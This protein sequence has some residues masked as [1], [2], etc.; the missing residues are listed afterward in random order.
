MRKRVL[1]G[2]VFTLAILFAG[3]VI[4]GSADYFDEINDAFNCLDSKVVSASLSFEEAVFAALAGTP[5]SRVSAMIVQQKSPSEYCWPKSGCTVK[6][7]AQAALAKMKMGEGVGNITEWLKTKSGV[8]QEMTWF[9]QISTDDN[10]PAGCVVNYD[11]AD[12]AV[13]IG[14][15]MKL[16]GSLGGC[17]SIVPSG[18]NMQI[19]TNC[20][21]KEFSVQCDKG[22]K[23][24]LLYTKSGGEE[25]YIS[26]QTHGAS[27]GA[28]TVEKITALCFKSGTSCDYEGGLWAATALYANGEDISEYSPYLRALSSDNEKYFPSAFLVSIYQGGDEHYARIMNSK[29]IRPEGTYWEMSFSP[30]GKYYDT[31]LAMLALK[32]ADS[33][34]VEASNTL[35]YLFTH[36]DSTGC[37]NNGNIRDTSF[38]IWAAKW[39][40]EAE[41]PECHIDSD[42]A[43]GRVCENGNCVITPS[44]GCDNDGVKESGEQCDGGDFADFG[45]GTEQCDEYQSDFT[46]G[47]LT[48]ENCQINASQCTLGEGPGPPGGSGNNCINNSDCPAGEICDNETCVT[49]TTGGGGP[50]NPNL[51]TD[52]ELAQLF[53]APSLSSCQDACPTPGGCYFPQATHS[54]ENPFEFCCTVEVI[55]VSCGS[56]GGSVCPWD[57]PCTIGDVESRDGP[58]CLAACESGSLG[59]TSD[60]DCPAGKICSS[61]GICETE[62]SLQCNDD[63]DCD[64]DENCQNGYCVSSGSDGGG[65]SLWIWIIILTILIVLVVLGIVY[66]DKLRVWWFQVTGKAKSSKVR[67]GWSPPGMT[68]GRRPPPRFGGA[69]GMMRPMNGRPMMRPRPAV[70]PANRPSENPSGKKDNEAEDTFKKLKEMSK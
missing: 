33:Q 23:T 31:A 44:T 19:G 1:T 51:I 57:Q 34:D 6:A 40:R 16:S 52:C 14:E 35:G 45:N 53:C 60:D 55:Q 49:N 9:L 25:V 11:G 17:L 42:C 64:S 5:N 41:E 22:F 50:Y 58:C 47:D 30:Y 13:S 29:K 8:T 66:R 28:W 54:C 21:D 46:G 48:C 70:P 20:L 69:P 61:V 32:G 3:S 2:L 68:L 4:A 56:L 62:T 7:T 67:P 43:D 65:S 15:D 38:I 59:C 37:W 18:Y 12:Y 36:Q 10:G 39:L 27:A 24:N 63:G 26:S